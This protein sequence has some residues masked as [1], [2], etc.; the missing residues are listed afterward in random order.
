M[1]LAHDL[2][3]YNNDSSGS[4]W[5]FIVFL[6]LV[7]LTGAC[8]TFTDKKELAPIEIGKVYRLKCDRDPFKA[9][10]RAVVITDTCNG[11][12]QY[13]LV[14]DTALMHPFDYRSGSCAE[15]RGYYIELEGHCK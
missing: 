1:S 7:F 13:V 8:E 4:G 10:D 12:I 14:K 9:L 15:F 6:V 11:Y 3:D 5:F 2:G